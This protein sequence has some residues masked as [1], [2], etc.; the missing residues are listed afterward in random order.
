MTLASSSGLVDPIINIGLLS[1]EPDALT[2]AE[3][4]RMINRF[5][6]AS[7][8]Q[9]YIESP[10]TKLPALTTDAGVIEY[11]RKFASVMRHY[12]GTA[13]ASRVDSDV[14][15]VNPDLTVK[16][17]KGLRVV[18]ASVF[19]SNYILDIQDMFAHLHIIS[20]SLSLAIPRLLF[21]L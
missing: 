4:Y 21:M 2:V 18:D 20:P 8:W 3:G 17:V 14:G 15:V 5:L 1:E 13:A 16:N 7:P 12:Q 9:N 10:F 11:A 6:T 19:V